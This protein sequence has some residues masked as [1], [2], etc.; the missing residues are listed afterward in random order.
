MT[1]DLGFGFFRRETGARCVFAEPQF[2]SDLL[3]IVIEGTDARVAILDPLGAYFALMR[4]LVASLV[5]CLSD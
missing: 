1:S 4:G 2:P 3:S 5:G